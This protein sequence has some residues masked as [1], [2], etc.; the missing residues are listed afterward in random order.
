MMEPRGG[1]FEE[2]KRSLDAFLKS[3]VKV[4]PE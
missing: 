1:L 3:L 2:Y 4:K